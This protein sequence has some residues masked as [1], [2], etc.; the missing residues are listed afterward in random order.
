MRAE[1]LGRWL[2]RLAVTVG[3]GSA[4]LGLST[5]VAHADAVPAGNAGPFSTQVIH[6][7][8]PIP[9]TPVGGAPVASPPPGTYVT[10]DWGWT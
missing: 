2:F 1:T 3:A 7:I 9:F 4:A 6:I 10:E 8:T 5:A